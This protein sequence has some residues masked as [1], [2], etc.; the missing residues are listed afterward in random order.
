MTSIIFVMILTAVFGGAVWQL[1][2]KEA[3]LSPSKK[4]NNAMYIIAVLAAAF[5][6]HVIGA[7]CY[8]GHPTDMGCFIGWSDKIF[9]NGL[10]QFY[11]SDGF[12]DYPPG[13][14]YIMWVLGAVQSGL[15]LSGG[16][17][18][19]VIKLPSIISDMLMGWMAYRFASKKYG[20]DISALFA[21]I[22]ALNPA[23]IMNSSVWGQIDS[24]LAIFCL[25]SVYFAS[26]KKLAPAFFSFA[27]GILIKPQALFF[28]PVLIYAVIDDVFLQGAFNAKKLGKHILWALAAIAAMFILFMPFGETPLKGISLILK[29]Y[30]DTLGEYQYMTIN[31]FNIYGAIGKNW[32]GLGTVSTVFGY[33]MIAVVVAYSAYVFF[34]SKSPAKYYI[35]A[36]ILNFGV[37]MLAIKMHERYAFPCIFMLL[38]ALIL[39]PNTKN[40]LMY[41]LFSLSQFFNMAWILFI[42]NQD[43]NKYFR[44]PVVSAASVINVLLMI[45]FIYIIQKDYVNYVE[46]LPAAAR[47]KQPTKGKNKLERQT[48]TARAKRERE[49]RF[50]RS[51]EKAKLT[52]I[53]FIAMAAIIIVYSITA[54]VNLGNRYAPETETVLTD[55]AVTVDLGGEK[56][57]AKT[58]FF[59]SARELNDNRSIDFKFLDKDKNEALDDNNTSGAVFYWTSKDTSVRARY[60]VISAERSDNEPVALRE[61]CFLDAGGNRI[62]PVNTNDSRVANLFDEQEMMADGKDFMT[63]TYFDEIYHARTAYEFIHRMS[64][65]EWTHPPLGKVFISLGIRAFGMNP[66][67]WRI[68]GTLFGIF[69]IPAIYLFAKRLLKKS[70]LAIVTTLLFTFDFMHFAQTRIATIDVYVTF[71]IILMYYY[72]YK[73]YEMSFYDTPLKKT[74][75]PLG[76]SGIFFGF[77]WASKWTGLY[78]GAGLAVIFFYTLYERYEEYRAALRTPKGSTSGI[79]HKTVIDRFRRNTLITLGFCVAMFVVVPIIIYT[80]S[81]IPY[82]NTPSGHGLKTITDNASSMY[83]YHSKTVADSTHPYSSHWYEWPIMY[84]PI[85]YFS[86]TLENGLK[87]GISSFGNPAVWWIGIGAPAYLTALAITVPLKERKYLG[88]NKYSFAGIYALIFGVFC[89]AAYVAGHG[90]EKLERLFPCMLFYSAVMVGALLL[91]L[92][93]DESIKQKSNRAALFLIIGYF[94][95]LVPWVFVVRTT[96]IYHY[97]PCVPFT[98]LMLGYSILTIWEDVKE[99]NRKKVMTAAFIYAGI[100]VVLFAMFYPVL[101]GHPCNYDYAKNFLKWFDSW[102]LL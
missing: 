49:T 35:T 100:A 39:L 21:A 2:M 5:V 98:V 95:E 88:V 48:V 82:F 89:A 71:F 68:V 14:V 31:A 60:V 9:K 64:V 20:N 26:E 42:Y 86:N 54:L 91:T 32:E 30:T 81:Y 17:Q 69:M 10:S 65:Y 41:G 87:Q 46:P 79:S 94:A 13:Y 90:N 75:V 27:A 23:V 33:L 77:A 92:T 25:L 51:G 7:L 16:A 4:E 102:V 37:Y 15:S 1:C 84:R 40:Y 57:I 3:V 36:F 99:K 52:R 11:A 63:G 22:F 47:K 78:A 73:Y 50:C 67:G 55:G 8:Y 24:I 29:Q 76:L 53:D 12:H 96:Y 85:W 56:D 74:L 101:S 34:R 45:F 93:Y 28:T 38:F 6:A 61:V 18:Q 70:P 58:V 97:F 59:N 72:M 19:L 44:N 83:T 43:I 62:E 80:L 66:F